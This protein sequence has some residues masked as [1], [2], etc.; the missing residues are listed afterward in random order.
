MIDTQVSPDFPNP[1]TSRM[2]THGLSSDLISVKLDGFRRVAALAALTQ[3]TLTARLMPARFHLLLGLMTIRTLAAPD[4]CDLL[5][6]LR[7][8]PFC[9]PDR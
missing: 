3:I 7:F 1:Y 9:S 8:S 4:R 5:I 6:L 2:P